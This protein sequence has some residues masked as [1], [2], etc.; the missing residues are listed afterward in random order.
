MQEIDVMV[1]G[2]D[3]PL[4]SVIMPAYNH[5]MF[6]ESAIRSV[7]ALNYHP[8]ELI[9]LDDGSSDKTYSIA[10]E[11]RR[12]SPIPM[13]VVSKENEGICKT[14]NKG[15]MLAQGKYVTFLASDDEFVS[16]RQR[17]HVDFLEASQ[18]ESVAGCYGQKSII[19]ENGNVVTKLVKQR[20]EYEDLFLALIKGNVP[21]SLQGST[22]KLS[23]VRD[24]KFDPDVFFEDWDFFLRVSLKYKMMYVP[25][26]S[27]RYRCLSNGM[28]R[29][30]S[31]MAKARLE[32][33]NKFRY[34]PRIVE[35]GIEKALSKVELANAKSFF[36]VDDYTGAKKHLINSFRNDWI[37]IFINLT[38][39]AKIMLGIRIVNK[40]RNVKGFLR[41]CWPA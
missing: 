22:L 20:M 40:I 34:H 27:F 11:L 25:G 2:H 32:I 29:N 19:D 28:N 10:C 13:D 15:I 31:M 1:E 8:L 4:V 21:L 30:V 5:E 41:S 18:D 38:F 7:W 14:L 3:R 26:I 35:Y 12:N 33:F 16:D 9:V 17:L 24:I 36:L 37:S 39:F 6:I 23:V